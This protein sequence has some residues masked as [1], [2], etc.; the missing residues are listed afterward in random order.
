M[1]GMTFETNSRWSLMT[2]VVISDHI[3]EAIAMATGGRPIF[4]PFQFQMLSGCS[5]IITLWF[6]LLGFMPFIVNNRL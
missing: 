5:E 2:N 6:Y 1:K 4:T 3:F